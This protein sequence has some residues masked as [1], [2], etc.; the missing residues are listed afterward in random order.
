M[1]SHFLLI[2]LPNTGKTSFLAALWYMV[3]QSNVA[4]ALKLDKL[5]GESQYLNQI[6][7]AWSEYRP[8]PR[9]KADS[10]KRVSMRLQNP[11][12][13][14]TGWLSFPDL[15]G[16]AFRSQWTQRQL[17]TSYDKNLQEAKGGVLFVN[18]ENIVKPHRVDTIN[19][20]LGAIGS[21]EVKRRAQNTDK[22][23]D[24][25][26]SPTQVQLVDLLQFMADRGHFQ[27]PFRLALAVSAWDRVIASN[28]RPSDWVATELPLLHQFLESNGDLFE[29]S[30][31]GVSAQGGRYALPH[32]WAGNFKEAQSFAKR[33]LERNDPISAWLWEKLDA[34]S[35]SALNE[36]GS[37]TETTEL[38][39]K[40]LAKDLNRLMAEPD[41]Y[42]ESRF[43]NIN[44]R[45]ETENFLRNG[46]LQNEEQ[47]LYLTRLL[48]EDAY[49]NE[50]SR[51][52]EH[53]SEASEL[54]RKI[55][56][57]RVLVVGDDTK[58]SH[59][60]T[61]PIRWLMH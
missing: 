61:E 16:E 29:V 24:S 35:Q 59:D 56:A 28:R 5:D 42:D 55:P 38:Q 17:A 4:C 58:T 10:E 33:V 51:E 27:P 53:E 39:R 20:V 32:F 6:R 13:E 54:E 11:E 36:M 41:F 60:V 45:S 43:S 46:I 14:Q 52:R 57:R 18:P 3:G 31:Y 8:V 49:P 9:N 34:S 47:K 44:F 22:P 15:S 48:L 37:G 21:D 1:H 2:G 12:T 50:L 25:E 40:S 26:R 7:D 23:W 19:E 30:F